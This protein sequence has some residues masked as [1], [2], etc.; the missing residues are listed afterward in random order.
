MEK[1][2]SF[3]VPCYNCADTVLASFASILDGNI[4][5]GDEIVLIDDAS[6]DETYK[7]LSAFASEYSFVKVVKHHRNKGS[8]A[9]G[10]NTGMDVAK[11]DLF[12]CL[13][14]DNILNPNSI[15]P[16]KE[17][18]F[19]NNLDAA[20]F[21]KIEYFS[22]DP[23]IASYEWVLHEQLEFIAALNDPMRTPCGSG[24]YLLTREIW[25]K[26]G[27]YNESVGG[28]YDSEIFGLR[29]LAEGA[30]FWTMPGYGYQHRTGY[31]STF[32]KEFDKK[33]RSLLFL[34]G[35][36][37]YLQLIHPEDIEYIFGTGRYSWFDDIEDRPLR[38]RS[39]WVPQVP[40]LARNV[41]EH[42]R[43]HFKI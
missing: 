26:A 36:M 30:K 9:A 23:S 18:L 40:S 27:R 14:S 16:L 38:A 24:N 11:N 15:A 19:S 3:I 1:N 32:A 7:I 28:A 21:G 12:F 10:R 8:A 42:I 22:D 35:I 2:I 34:A 37:D 31:E 20:A 29:L 5:S 33:N 4:K 6:T 41:R 13:D 25:K 39:T 43:K 17:F